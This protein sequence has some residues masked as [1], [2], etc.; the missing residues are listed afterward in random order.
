MV[1]IDNDIHFFFKGSLYSIKVFKQKI[2]MIRQVE[3]SKPF[4]MAGLQ[5]TRRQFV[6]YVKSHPISNPSNISSS[7]VQFVNSRADL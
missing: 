4:S 5:R 6:A 2:I 7:F 3:F 1:F